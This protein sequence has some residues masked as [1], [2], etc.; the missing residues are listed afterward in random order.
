MRR[1][2][3]SERAARLRYLRELAAA[4]VDQAINDETIERRLELV[5]SPRTVADVLHAQERRR[6]R[7]VRRWQR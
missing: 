2:G 5:L 4:L 6:R 7:E 1:A 3:E